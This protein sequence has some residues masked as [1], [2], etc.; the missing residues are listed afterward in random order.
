VARTRLVACLPLFLVGSLYVGCGRV[1][2]LCQSVGGAFNGRVGLSVSR[3]QRRTI[4]NPGRIQANFRSHREMFEPNRVHHFSIGANHA[5][6]R[7][8]RS[9]RD[10]SRDFRFIAIMT[11]CASTGAPQL[12][13]CD[14]QARIGPL[15]TS[16]ARPAAG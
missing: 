7:Q 15:V 5:S 10:W 12:G 4:Y 6:A 9:K 8:I 16:L 3:R 14:I 2:A 1:Q 11:V 13:E